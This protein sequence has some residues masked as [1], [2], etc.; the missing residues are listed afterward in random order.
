MGAISSK[1]DRGDRCTLRVEGINIDTFEILLIA[2]F[3]VIRKL[4]SFDLY[5]LADDVDGGMLF[6]TSG[7]EL[8]ELRNFLRKNKGF[9]LRDDLDGEA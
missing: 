9:T 4:S 7:K 1:I 3:R 8:E 5:F 6:A 2:E